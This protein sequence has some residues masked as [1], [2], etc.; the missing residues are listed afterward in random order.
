[1]HILELLI[2]IG[3]NRRSEKT[4]I[5]WQLELS[6][7]ELETFRKA[8]TRGLPALRQ[9]LVQLGLQLSANLLA[10]LTE[11]EESNRQTIYQVADLITK[12]IIELQQLTGHR[13]SFTHVLP[14][15]E[16]NRCRLLF[17]HEHSPT[18]L[19]AGEL[20]MRLL[21][22]KIPGLEWAEDSDTPGE[23]FAQALEIFLEHRPGCVL[24][25]DAQAI[26]DAAARLDVPCVKLERD[27]YG[28][29]P[30][31]FRIRKN[32]LLKLG[33]SCYH[34]IVDGTL[35]VDRNAGLVPLLFDREKLFLKM[36]ELKLPVARQDMEFRHLITA[37]RAIRVAQHIGFP[38]VLKP[39]SR[40]RSIE[41]SQAEA[42]KALVTP[43]EVRHAFEQVQKTS[44]KV[45][46]EKYVPGS[47][48]YVLVANHQVICIISADSFQVF[49]SPVHKTIPDMAMQVSKSVDCGLLSI[50]LI[51]TDLCKS[52]RDTGGAVVDIDFAPE[53]DK[54]LRSNPALMDTAAEG[55]IRWLY[56]DG[57]P[58][59]IPLIAVTGTNGK[60]TTSR[61]ITRIVNQAGYKPGLA[62]TS[63]IYLNEKFHE[64]G[65]RSGGGGH[66]ILFESRDINIGV[67]ETARGA[68]AHSGFMFDWCDVA[69]CL[70]V[71]PEH[72]GEYGIDTLE[73]MT[74]IKRSVLQRAKHA[75]VLNADYQT[76]RSM[77]PFNSGQQVYVASLESEFTEIQNQV[78]ESAC[79]CVLEKSS[80][81]EWIV[82]YESGGNR[83]PIMPVSAIPASLGGLVGF[84]VSNA[85]H[86]ICASHAMGIGV[87]DIR[88]GLST[89]E[90]SY[91]STPGRLNFYNELPFTVIMDY[92]HNADGMKQLISVLE[93][94][95]VRGRKIIL[96]AAS[97]NRRD[98]ENAEFTLCAE[99]Y[100]DFFFCRTYASERGR[101]RPE[102]TSLMKAT[103]L[104]AGVHEDRIYLVSSPEDG[105]SQAMK[106]ARP[107]DLVVLCPG[108]A[109]IAEMWQQITTFQPDSLNK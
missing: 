82:L 104:D 99:N 13:V 25:L 105:A 59:R 76:C 41:T 69:V 32:G 48:F 14:S 24:P 72:L 81:I 49:D 63:G 57:K 12:I 9:S 93:K 55:F 89:F 108:T 94:L 109:E 60:T 3:P 96:F 6:P 27:P 39:V 16:P 31:D 38:V 28:E 40:K 80:N 65:D 77:L 70:N 64:K 37:K 61:M 91:E 33:H 8:K 7:G 46:V 42:I 34:T 52:L 87:D 54:L 98:Q 66:H 43:E 71:A 22:E 44:Q 68:V 51:T 18:A 74:K 19:D 21:S 15:N 84:N 86:A 75:V 88:V 5:E 45:M 107:G 26:I 53:L 47:T 90:A 11:T 58:S 10:E 95:E 62:C 50:C 29:L 2:Y 23:G 97:A 73:Q 35:C 92:V 102:T 106:L 4:L 85:Q 78:G 56:P 1:M 30:G 20:A 100:F 83:L 36:V 101:L 17:E 79:I 103:L 67:L